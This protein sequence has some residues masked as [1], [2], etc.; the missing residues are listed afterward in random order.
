MEQVE[1]RVYRIMDSDGKWIVRVHGI[2]SGFK[3]HA[4]DSDNLSIE[5]KFDSTRFEP[6]IVKG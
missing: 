2:S 6:I 1:V 5:F 4:N 3:V